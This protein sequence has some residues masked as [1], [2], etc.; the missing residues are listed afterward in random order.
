MAALNAAAGVKAL[1]QEEWTAST[2][3]SAHAAQLL[4]EAERADKTQRK[5]VEADNAHPEQLT[6]E[7]VATYDSA[8]S[9]KPLQR[10]STTSE[11]G[12]QWK[13]DS[14]RTA[15]KPPLLQQP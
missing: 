4:A 2:G 13:P 3:A 6:I 1:A 11:T 10:A 15:A 12:K 5:N 14:Q 8:E 9:K 7:A